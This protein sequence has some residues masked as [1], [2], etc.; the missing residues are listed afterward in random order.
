MDLRQACKILGL[1][2]KDNKKDIKLKYRELIFK[3][4][5]DSLHSDPNSLEKAKEINEAFEILK[6]NKFK[7]LYTSS[8]DSGFKSGFSPDFKTSRQ[9]FY[10]TDYSYYEEEDFKSRDYRHFKGKDLSN[11]YTNRDIFESPS[12]DGIRQD[13]FIKLARG[14]YLWEPDKEDFPS[15][16]HSIITETDS[17]L[18][19]VELA[20]NKGYNPNINYES[21]RN[22]FRMRLFHL[23]AKDFINP[24]YAL[25]K[26]LSPSLTTKDGGRIY[27]IKASLGTVGVDDYYH[28]LYRLKLGDSLYPSKLKN[29]R[30]SVVNNEGI[31]LG[32]L[33]IED[34]PLLYIVIPI[35]ERRL[36]MVKIKVKDIKNNR[37][38]RPYRIHIGLSLFIK[39][40]KE[41]LEE[42]IKIDNYN[43]YCKKISSNISDLI[44]EY[45]E[46]LL[47]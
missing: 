6:K 40:E 43:E 34:D 22:Y 31:S 8:Y 14:K 12:K 16:I 46:A 35:L 2:S 37:A 36:A 33:T 29:N 21:T 30:L 47:S 32:N 3:Y 7:V 17:L 19:D 4:H 24:I 41:V 39:I 15:F 27:E 23:L 11:A 44:K 5:P 26:L 13:A 20:S 42:E 9:G 28:K 38:H 1:T 25:R 10:D 18:S 45:E